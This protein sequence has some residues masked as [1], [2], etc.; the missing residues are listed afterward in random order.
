MHKIIEALLGARA[1]VMVLASP[2]APAS[3]D[4]GNRPSDGLQQLYREQI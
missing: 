3:A 4:G 1:I 2:D